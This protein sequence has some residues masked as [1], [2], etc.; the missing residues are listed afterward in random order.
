[1]NTSLSRALA[2]GIPAAIAAGV[3]L[4]SPTLGAQEKKAAKAN[5][6]QR[7]VGVWRLVSDSNTGADGVKKAGAGFGDD[8][9]GIL[10]FMR[11]GRYASMITRKD[12]PKFAS[13]NRLQGTAEENK[14][15][16]QGSIAHFGTY[17]VTPDGKLL[18]LKPEAATWPAWVGVEQK[19]NLTLKGDQMK[20]TLA[21][22]F[23]GTSELIY[24]R[25]K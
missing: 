14:A 24:K 7:I 13:G 23:G 9:K 17:S 25:A 4:V 11:D 1:M 12:L 5:A 3:L 6:N 16:V 8:P 20:Y 18:M 19:R 10:I 22:S 2:K 15:I 21:A